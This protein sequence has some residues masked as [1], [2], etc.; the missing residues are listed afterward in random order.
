MHILLGAWEGGGGYVARLMWTSRER[1]SQPGSSTPQT[2]SIPTL[3]W[4]AEAQPVSQPPFPRSA[5][6]ASAAFCVKME[7]FGHL[8]DPPRRLVRRAINLR[9]HPTPKPSSLRERDTAQARTVQ[10]TAG[11]RGG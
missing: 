2:A 9:Q 5:R 4:Q 3:G 10:L 11:S 7:W 1:G 6:V 8:A